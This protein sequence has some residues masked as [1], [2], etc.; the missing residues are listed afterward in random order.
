MMRCKVF[1]LLISLYSCSSDKTKPGNSSD[2]PTAYEEAL[3]HPLIEFKG[4]TI[5]SRILTPPGYERI[6]TKENSFANY[7]RSL[8][9]KVPG[10]KV[11]YY[12]GETKPNDV[13]EAVVD[14]KIGEKDLHQ[15][16]DAIMRLRAEHLWLQGAYDKIRFNFTNGFVVKY[17]KW[18]EGK[19]M[20]VDGNKTYWSRR[21][22]PTE[23][24]Y[25]SFWK[26]M[27]LIFTYAGTASLSNELDRA[28]INDISIGDIFIQGGHPGHAVIVVDLATN[29]EN[30]KIFLLAQSY[31]PAQEIHILKNEEDNP[32]YSIT[33]NNKISTPE[34]EFNHNDLKRF[35]SK[36]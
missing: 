14:L 11:K 30:D 29:K 9:V 25:E 36:K 6:P 4:T 18:L 19:R 34:W 22:V 28:D 26:Y 1:L 2:K 13:H 16:A 7:L 24:N 3:A 27:E 32:W 8:P 31:M 10:S 35:S 23:N 33:A 15:C 5:E 20:I 17:S 21:T 12:N